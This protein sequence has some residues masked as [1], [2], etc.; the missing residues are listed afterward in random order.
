MKQSPSVA[1]VLLPNNTKL[2]Q[3]NTTKYV[4]RIEQEDLV[5]KREKNDFF[6]A[7]SCF[8]KYESISKQLEKHQ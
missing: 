7:K 2:T 6:L 5:K 1:K 3:S 8:L 4:W